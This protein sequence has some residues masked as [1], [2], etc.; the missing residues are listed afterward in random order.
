M[1]QNNINAYKNAAQTVSKIKQIIM[2]YDTAIASIY[3]AK[4]AIEK[5]DIQERY[6]K[7][8]KAYL[9]ISGLR[10]SLDES[11]NP[12]FVE[13]MRDWYSGIIQ[14]IMQISR[15][16]D[17]RMC[18]SCVEYIMTMRQSWIDLDSGEALS[19]NATQE[20]NDSENLSESEYNASEQ[21]NNDLDSSEDDDSDDYFTDSYNNSS[22][23]SSSPAINA[24]NSSAL[25]SLNLSI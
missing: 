12:E 7:I 24:Y 25:N 5:N 16:S 22:S 11:Q 19:A 3:Q 1:V 13:T 4:E 2:L 15:D 23:Q 20:N 8:E 17:A 21:N 14:M 9:I 18:E 6:N 10:D